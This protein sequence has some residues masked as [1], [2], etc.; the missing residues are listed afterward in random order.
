MSTTVDID[1]NIKPA[2]WH[3]GILGNLIGWYDAISDGAKGVAGATNSGS[4]LYSVAQGTF[5]IFAGPVD[6]VPG[7]ITYELDWSPSSAG[8]TPTLSVVGSRVQ[9][10]LTALDAGSPG[11]TGLGIITAT[12]DGVL[13]NNSLRLR[14][15]NESGGTVYWDVV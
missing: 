11:S 2:V 5:D 8:S 7:I 1:R 10:L 15:T 9:V 12:L 13:A 14:Y 4:G 6:V 3:I